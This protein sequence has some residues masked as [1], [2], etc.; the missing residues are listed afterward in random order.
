MPHMDIFLSGFGIGG[1][2]HSG[3]LLGMHFQGIAGNSHCYSRI[4]AV[5]PLFHLI[6]TFTQLYFVFLNPKVKWDIIR[7]L[8]SIELLSYLH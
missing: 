8:V 1:M 7:T 6:F 3:L 5:K 4:Q 2:I